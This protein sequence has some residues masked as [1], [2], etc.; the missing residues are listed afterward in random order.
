[1]KQ[2]W[3]VTAI[4]FSIK[5]K[6]KAL[7]LAEENNV[8]IEYKIS[9]IEKFLFPTEEYDALALIFVHFPSTIRENVHKSLIKSL[10]KGGI[11]LIEA[12]SKSQIKNDSGGPKDLS[13]LYCIEDLRNDFSELSIDN[14][15]EHHIILKEGPYH[16]GIAD[17]IR[18]KATLK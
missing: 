16:K 13:S 1:V 11:I 10:K 3:E 8:R 14:L 18:F 12:F 9:P 2:G 7:K 15:S 4:D 5:A 17:V 6:E